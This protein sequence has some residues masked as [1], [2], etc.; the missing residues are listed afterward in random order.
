MTAP[1]LKRMLCIEDDPDI[2]LI[3][4]C[5]LEAGNI[6]VA[7]CGEPKQAV[8]MAADFK[9]DLILMDVMMPEQDGPTTLRQLHANPATMAIPIVFM[10]ARIQTQEL[11][12]YQKMGA[13]AVIAKPFDPMTLMTELQKLYE[14]HHEQS[15]A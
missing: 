10:T 13:L 11:K 15:A 8:A 3:L 6:E 9:P 4:Q 12:D 14:R 5:T 1:S 7:I 2:Q